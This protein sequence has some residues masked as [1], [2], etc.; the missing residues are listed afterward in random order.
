MGMEARGRML[1]LSAC[2]TSGDETRKSTL[3]KI[4][5]FLQHP[6]VGLSPPWVN[7]RVG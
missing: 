1:S 4:K 5:K 2:W 3:K 7:E 6:A